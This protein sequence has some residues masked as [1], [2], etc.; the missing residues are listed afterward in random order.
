[1]PA[2]RAW[3]HLRYH[4]VDHCYLLL[5]LVCQ[6][7]AAH[8]LVLF[9]LPAHAAYLLTCPRAAKAN[10]TA[11]CES[12]FITGASSG[13]GAALAINLAGRSGTRALHLAGRDSERLQATRRACR[14]VAAN[15]LRI[16]VIVADVTA[17]DAMVG[18]PACVNRRST[19][20]RICATVAAP[21]LP[22]VSP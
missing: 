5:Q 20:V 12:Y 11:H 3:R 22:L 7:V 10:K 17:A 8:V 9:A 4:A 16:Y 18:R 6:L 2:P 14:S 1:M 19:S 21:H 15:D 13:I